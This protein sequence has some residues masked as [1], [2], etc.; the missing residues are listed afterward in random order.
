MAR[1]EWLGL[2]VSAHGYSWIETLQLALA[3]GVPFVLTSM[4]D[5]AT[6]SR[7]CPSSRAFL[8]SSEED[9]A[10]S[11]VSFTTTPSRTHL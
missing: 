5:E 8:R 1:D 6:L 7:S 10:R 2:Y 4:S 11:V 9:R 3:R